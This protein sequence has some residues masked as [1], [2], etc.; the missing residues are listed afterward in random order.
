MPVLNREAL[1]EN[2]LNAIREF[3]DRVG[4]KRAQLDVSGG[5]DSAVM[6]GLLSIALG[7]ENVTAVY[8]GIHSSPESQDRA[9]E[10]AGYFDVRLIVLDLTEAYNVISNEALLG[11]VRA[12]YDT[13]EVGERCKNDPTVEGSFRSCLRA[14]VGRFLNRLTGGG[15]R[16]GTGNECEDRWLR[17]FQKGGDGEVDTNPIAMLS[18]GEVYQLADILG[19]PTSI[20]DA[21]PSPDL[22]GKGEVH[23]DEDELLTWAGAPFTYSRV[24]PLTGE[25]SRVGTIERVSRYAD[26]WPG[27]FDPEVNSMEALVN[28][29]HEHPALAPLPHALRKQ[30]LV[31]ARKVEAMTRHKW[32]PNCP[33]LGSREELVEAGILTNTLP[34]LD[35]GE[36]NR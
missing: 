6:L 5:I 30:L 27:L 7:P 21:L 26:D 22:W 35:S 36:E 11:L 4:T 2:R 8:Q 33:S 14:P 18:K 29:S 10:V 3:H 31:A 15:I 9:E 13:A 34:D 1:L 16:H 28:G 12:D 20:I 17:F 32:N 24:D 19:V 25:Y 23:N